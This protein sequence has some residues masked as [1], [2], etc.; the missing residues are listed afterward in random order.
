MNT[1][2]HRE[3]SL[4]EI[5]ALGYCE[6]SLRKQEVSVLLHRDTEIHREELI[7]L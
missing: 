2:W 7:R 4:R 1:K 5:T 3:D 6:F